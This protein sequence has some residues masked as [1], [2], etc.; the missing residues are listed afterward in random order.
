MQL[1][2]RFFNSKL[3]LAQCLPVNVAIAKLVSA[4][5]SAMPHTTAASAHIVSDVIGSAVQLTGALL[6][7]LQG[8]K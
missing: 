7:V 8:L 4:A 2:V 1:Y 6:A 5:M 3:N